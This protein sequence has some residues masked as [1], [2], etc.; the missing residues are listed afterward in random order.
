MSPLARPAWKAATLTAR[1]AFVPAEV[2]E[3]RHA[4]GEAGG[5]EVDGLL[6]GFDASLEGFSVKISQLSLDVTVCLTAIEAAP[7]GNGGAHDA[8]KP[9]TS[10][11]A[12]SSGGRTA[13]DLR[14]SLKELIND[15]AE[16]VEREKLLKEELKEDKLTG[17]LRE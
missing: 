11:P 14:R 15:W 16:V 17:K 4:S 9:T 10:I 12:S 5:V 6:P 2:Q 8:T 7:F 3:K 1:R 13:R